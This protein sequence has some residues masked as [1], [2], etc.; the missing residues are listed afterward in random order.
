MGGPFFV[1]CMRPYALFGG[2]GGGTNRAGGPQQ[3]WLLELP[4]AP[5]T[6]GIQ[7]AK[8]LGP[9]ST[10]RDPLRRLQGQRILRFFCFGGARGE[11][12]KGVPKAF[13]NRSKRAP[14]A[15]TVTVTHAA[16]IDDR[17]NL[18]QR[19]IACEQNRLGAHGTLGSL[20]LLFVDTDVCLF[21]LS[22]LSSSWKTGT[23]FLFLR[24]GGPRNNCQLCLGESRIEDIQ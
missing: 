19:R 10:R 8:A 5:A 2:E 6:R 4:L 14:F 9:P 7:G 24:S 13:K 3:L 17:T 23:M 18:G 20:C 1:G 22:D 12:S 11:G 15:T 21:W 16:A